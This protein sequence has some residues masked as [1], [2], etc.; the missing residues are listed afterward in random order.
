MNG[1]CSALIEYSQSKFMVKELVAAAG[2]SDSP[3]Q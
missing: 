3:V 1:H 2:S